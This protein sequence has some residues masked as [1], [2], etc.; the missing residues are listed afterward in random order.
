M[1]ERSNASVG[2]WKVEHSKLTSIS[3]FVHNV[4]RLNK[5]SVREEASAELNVEARIVS[6][7]AEESRIEPKSLRDLNTPSIVEKIGGPKVDYHL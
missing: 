4:F 3:V 6:R 1:V 5:R 2:L 7:G